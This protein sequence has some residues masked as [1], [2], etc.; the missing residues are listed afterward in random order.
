MNARG[1]YMQRAAVPGTQQ[2]QVLGQFNPLNPLPGAYTSPLQYGLYQPP[3]VD[4]TVEV[5]L[6]SLAEVFKRQSDP[7]SEESVRK[8][9]RIIS[10]PG[11]S[12][13]Q[14]PAGGGEVKKLSDLNG[15]LEWAAIY[16]EHAFL[17]TAALLAIPALFYVLGKQQGVAQAAGLGTTE[18]VEQ[19]D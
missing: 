19:T 9:Y 2:T 13:E 15:L 6:A 4:P 10:A 17:F 7:A 18:V 12:L 11:Y 3:R 16:R 5:A 14:R 1:R 8:I